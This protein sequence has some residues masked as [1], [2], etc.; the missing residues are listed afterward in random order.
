MRHC[1]REPWRVTRDKRTRP[2]VGTG[3]CTTAS[4]SQ[5][6]GIQRAC[7]GCTRASGPDCRGPSHC[8]RVCAGCAFASGSGC[9]R[10]G[11]AGRCCALGRDGGGSV[12][13][14]SHRVATT[15]GSEITGQ[16]AAGTHAA[17]DALQPPFRV[18]SRVT[19]HTR[20]S[21]GSQQPQG[22][23]V[24]HLLQYMFPSHA[25]RLACCAPSV[26]TSWQPSVLS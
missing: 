12:H 16:V 3:I 9:V 24:E 13:H 1:H 25:C 4:G 17:C 22:P 10:T 5:Q 7:F 20:D 11:T 18:V 2:L 26:V 19:T 23:V 15:P 21:R 14:S 6:P 8:A